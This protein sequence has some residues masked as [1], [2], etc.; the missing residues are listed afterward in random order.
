MFMF[1][2]MFMLMLMLM[3]VLM[4]LLMLMLM[5]MLMFMLA[6]SITVMLAA[7]RHVGGAAVSLRLM[8]SFPRRRS[9][10][11]IPAASLRSDGI[12]QV[13]LTARVRSRP[14]SFSPRRAFG[15][16]R[17]DRMGG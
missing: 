12:D 9:A 3:L 1:M 8:A 11:R 5:L 15:T 13:Q 6:V 4:L 10:A 14:C 16:G 17:I 2:F 7:C